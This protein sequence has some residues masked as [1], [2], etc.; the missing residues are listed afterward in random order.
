[1]ARE[2]DSG[3]GATARKRGRAHRIG[4][5]R[6]R[7][8]GCREPLG[9]SES[10][11]RAAAASPWSSTAT[12]LL[13]ARSSLGDVR[14]L[15]RIATPSARAGRS[16]AAAFAPTAIAPALPDH[17]GLRI[18]GTVD[19]F[20][21]DDWLALQG[22]G[23]GDAASGK[24]LSDYLQAANVRVGTF[25]LFGYRWPDVRGVLQATPSGWRVDV[26]GPNAA[27]QVLIPETFTGAQPLRAT[28]ERLVLEKAASRAR[29]ERR[30]GHAAIR[31]IFRTCRC[32]SAICASALARS[33]R[34]ICKRRACRRESASTTS[35]MHRRRRRAPKAQ[36]D[37]L[38]HDGRTAFLAE[39]D[40]R[41][42]TTSPR[43]CAH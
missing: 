22:Q 30:R 12:T 19:R 37:W 27:G 1:M 16:I 5:A 36:G 24:P 33:A 32:M 28:L 7:A 18:E 15:I 14:S 41:R 9:K 10:E 35:T 4:P 40:D 26:D 6:A 11:Q 17:R 39:G 8:S 31:A 34:S 43:R 13:L 25:E 38:D 20:V 21:L 23:S 29:T 2:F 3:A 42:A